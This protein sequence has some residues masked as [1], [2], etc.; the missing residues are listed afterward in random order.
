[1]TRVLIGK[2]QENKFKCTKV[3]KYGHVVVAVKVAV[4]IVLMIYSVT[5]IT[6]GFLLTLS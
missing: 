3:V 6:D 5:I 4:V 1:M 2:P